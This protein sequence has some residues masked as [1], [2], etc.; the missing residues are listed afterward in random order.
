M[1]QFKVSTTQADAGYQVLEETSRLLEELGSEGWRVYTSL[2]F[3][4]RC[5]EQVD[6]R[7]RAALQ[8]L[9]RQQEDAHRLAR[10]LSQ[11]MERYQAAETAVVGEYE[12]AAAQTENSILSFAAI[13]P[14]LLPLLGPGAIPG[15]AVLGALFAQNWGNHWPKD[16]SLFGGAV[17]AAGELLG[18]G[19]SGSA[20][21]NGPSYT[22]SSEQYFGWNEEGDSWGA[23]IKGEVE[24]YLFQGGVEGQWGLLSGNV[25]AALGQ[26]GA[27]GEVKAV[28]F[29]D[30]AFHPELSVNAG[31]EA[32]GATGEVGVQFGTDDY[33]LHVGAEGTAGHAVAET[34]VSLSDEGV[35]L[36][37]EVGAAAL[38]GEVEGG[39]TIFGV[40]VD[41][42]ASGAVGAVGV[43]GEFSATT[44]SFTI[45]GEIAALLGLG[46]NIKVSW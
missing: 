37:G 7:L 13:L 16:Y 30:G 17:E 44:D 18:I 4:I 29:E 11:S 28:L 8:R 5:R 36:K 22:L 25:E 27:Y 9:E 20:H 1:S 32:S 35:V 43:G 31:V 15:L 24:G 41:V 46:L 34:E 23:A 21:W 10:G 39:F 38:E 42:S 33:N 26:I 3:Q 45:G 6:A 12:G 14:L 40:N 19:A 2:S